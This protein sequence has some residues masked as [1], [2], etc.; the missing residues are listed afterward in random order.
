MPN[1]IDNLGL[2]FIFDNDETMMNFFGYLVENGK[3]IPGYYGCPTFFNPMGSIDLFPKTK[4]KEDGQLEVVGLDTHCC[5][6][7][8]WEMRN[9]GIDITPKGSLP[10]ERAFMFKSNE[11]GSGLIPINLINADILPSFLEDDVVKMQM[12]AFP[13]DINYYADEDA[14]AEDQPETEDGKHWLLAD[15]SLLPAKFLSNHSIKDD[16]NDEEK[17]YENDDYVLFKGV[18]KKVFHG[19]FEMEGHKERIYIRCIIDTNYGE[20]I[21]AHTIDQVL[22]EQHDNIKVGSIISGVCVLSGD[23]A[24][25]EYENGFVKDFD[26]DFR[27]LRQVIAKGEAERMRPVLCED[28]V[29]ISDASKKTYVGANEII[30]RFN[31]IE[32]ERD[33]K[34]FVTPATIV[35][36]D[37][38]E[39]E[40][41]VGTRCMLI[42]YNT[43]ENVS[44]IVFMDVTESGDIKKI[45]ITED[46]RYH[47][48]ADEK[49][50][51]PSPLDDMELPESVI[52]PIYNRAQ[53]H[54]FIDENVSLEELAN[55][56]VAAENWKINVDLMLEA[57]RSNPQPDVEIALENIFGYLFAKAIEKT[58]IKNKKSSDPNDVLAISYD[59]TDAFE[60]KLVTRL[61]EENHNKVMKLMKKG[62]QFYKDFKFFIQLSEPNDDKFV[63]EITNALVVVQH[64]GYLYALN[65]FA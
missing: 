21:F 45:H 40:Y 4:R 7:N 23:V 60:G 49:P 61:N 46:S 47:F 48:T 2:G 34:C 63:E 33:Y 10:T 42:S 28:A 56:V 13:L 38:D 29:Y 12:C 39:L 59:P 41:P 55:G 51:Y 52:K 16:E 31:Y 30:E 22:A 11:D 1:F 27:L 54:G 37:S 25:R 5:G 43:E 9:T 20:L 65:N 19:V 14:Y 62:Q 64:I 24:I 15:G 44:A 18:V 3:P 8:I 53:F 32:K 58:I 26:N 36:V 57:L 35:Q 50:S 17:E 6:L